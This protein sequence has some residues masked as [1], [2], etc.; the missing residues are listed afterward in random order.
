M[1]AVATGRLLQQLVGHVRQRVGSR[2]HGQARLESALNSSG[3]WAP[4]PRW[5]FLASA[6]PCSSEPKIS[7]ARW[8]A[9]QLTTEPIDRRW[10]RSRCPFGSRRKNAKL[11]A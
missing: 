10:K 1:P 4:E 5:G 6:A 7:F 8:L 11:V 9:R 2:Q 3:G